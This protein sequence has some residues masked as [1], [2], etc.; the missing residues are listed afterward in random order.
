MQTRYY[1]YQNKPK[2]LS[3]SVSYLS[4]K[5]LIKN[6]LYVVLRITDTPFKKV[7]TYKDIWGLSA[8]NKEQN[9]LW[10]YF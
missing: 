9:M 10:I 3:K 8:N 4:L 1:I 7:Y 6:L 5:R 2:A